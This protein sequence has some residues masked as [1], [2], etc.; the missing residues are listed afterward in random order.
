MSITK[1]DLKAFFAGA[2][3]PTLAGI[4][5]YAAAGADGATAGATIGILGPLTAPGFSLNPCLMQAYAGMKKRTLIAAGV[6][7]TTPAAVTAALTLPFK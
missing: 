7:I 1:Q 2:A 5:G 6:G 4:M 3:F